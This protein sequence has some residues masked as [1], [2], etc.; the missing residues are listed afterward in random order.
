[1]IYRTTRGIQGLARPVL[2]NLI[3]GVRICCERV[4]RRR[5][6]WFASCYNR[7]PDRFPTPAVS[8]A[9]RNVMLILI[10]PCRSLLRIPWVYSNLA[11]PETTC[12]LL[13]GSS[14][15]TVCPV[16]GLRN[17][18]THELRRERLTKTSPDSDRSSKWADRC[19]PLSRS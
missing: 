11:F 9:L 18:M 16:L 5:N 17:V 2:N 19:M 14:T 12:K 15:P 6:S 13:C 10:G 1:M 3:K 8:C 4:A 7:P